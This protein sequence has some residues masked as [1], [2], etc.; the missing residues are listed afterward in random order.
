MRSFFWTV[1]FLSFF[2][3]VLGNPL[4]PQA[5][6]DSPTSYD[7]LTPSVL[8]GPFISEPAVIALLDR[9]DPR[10]C[11]YSGP[12][13]FGCL[14]QKQADVTRQQ[15]LSGRLTNPFNLAVFE[16]VV[17]TI[18][19][20]L[21]ELGREARD[22]TS[23]ELSP[24]FLTDAFSRVELV[25]IINRMDRQFTGDRPLGAANHDSCGEISVIYRFGYTSPSI[26]GSRLP[27][28]MNVVFP[29]LPISQ[30]SA[31][32]CADI[33]SRW[34]LEMGRS[35]TRTPEEIVLDLQDPETGILSTI[36]GED[37]FRI[38]LNMQAY[39]IKV[40]NDNTGLGS[41]AKYVIRVFRWSPDDGGMFI[42][43]HLHNQIDRARMLGIAEGDGNSCSRNPDRQFS[44][45]EFVDWL[46]SSDVMADMDRGTLTIPLKYLACRAISVS[47]GGPHRSWNQPFWEDPST[48]KTDIISDDDIRAAM[49]AYLAQPNRAFSFVK[50]V[51]DVRARLN[52]ATCSGCHQ[53]RAIAGFH[54]PG[55]DRLGTPS[56]NAVLLPGSPHFYGDQPRRR[57]ILELFAHGVTPTRYQLAGSYAAR[58]LNRFGNA[59][60]NLDDTTQLLGGWGSTCL[61]DSAGSQRQWTCGDD[62]QCVAPFVS[63]NAP[64]LGTCMPNDGYQIGDVMQFG[65]IVST[66]LG[67]ETY[68]RVVPEPVQGDTRIAAPSQSSPVGNSYYVAHQEYYSG[69]TGTD[70]TKAGAEA[71]RDSATGG[72]PAGMLRLS[73]CTGLPE[74]ATCGF[75]ATSGFAKC[76]GDS[77]RNFT[78]CFV[79]YTAY[80]G[81]RACDAATPCRDD[82]I[83][84]QPISGP[85]PDGTLISYTPA[86][87]QYLFDRRRDAFPVGERPGPYAFGEDMPDMEWLGRDD[88]RGYCMPPYFVFQFRVDGHPT[89]LPGR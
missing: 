8:D 15:E 71:K 5:N 16:Q 58:P 59:P 19:G 55:A 9:L 14:V 73:E 47:P 49:A 32:D 43:S 1:L 3:T 21:T 11:A 13:V 22:G 12:L 45:E 53:A 23:E 37:I 36:A 72:F 35:T 61:T 77:S 84:L 40:S 51:D 46:S 4:L 48:S 39:R 30:S 27:V 83:C 18:K 85:G 78:D 17:G 76:I 31:V 75:T 26:T 33:A 67:R 82:Y 70:A 34:L 25:G 86:T 52:D 62:L 57:E 64:S 66:E 54:F 87:A 29:A 50:S 80:A 65:N 38:E 10:G 44:R 63:A 42:V 69:S 41:T 6:E 79:R 74:E 56:F 24:L 28:T 68:Q 20:D 89:P 7:A 2:A 88:K 81:L 60:W